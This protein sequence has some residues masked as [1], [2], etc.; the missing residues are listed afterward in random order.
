MLITMVLP[1]SRV[2]ADVSV[3]ARETLGM[4]DLRARCPAGADDR[5]R[6][7]KRARIA[8]RLGLLL[9]VREGRARPEREAPA[10]V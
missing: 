7:T 6:C 3:K 8:R 10:R 4:D 1:L 5:N 2:E 9:G